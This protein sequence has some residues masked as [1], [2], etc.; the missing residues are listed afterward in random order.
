M[1]S[2]L[3][4]SSRDDQRG[5]LGGTGGGRDDVL[6]G[7][8]G[9]AQVRVREV[10]DALVVGVR[11][12]RGH[13]ALD[14][15]E[16]LVS[17]TLAIGATQLVVQE[18]LEM[19]WWLAAS[20]LSWLTPITMVMSSSLAGAEMRTFLAPAAM[21]FSASAFLVKMPVDSMTMSTPSSPHGSVGGVALGEHLDGVAVDGD[22]VGG[23]ATPR[24]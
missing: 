14:D 3:P 6:G 16:V 4:L 8:A 11:V 23:V 21:C 19:T 12:D 18:A 7:G 2:S 17:R 9:A 20:Y 5:G 15:A 24:P 22:R 13:Q 1:P 10:Q